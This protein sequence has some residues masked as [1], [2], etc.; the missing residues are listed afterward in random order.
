MH[1]EPEPDWMEIDS[2][3]NTSAKASESEIL[4]PTASVPSDNAEVTPVQKR[5]PREA[6]KVQDAFRYST[7]LIQGL[8]RGSTVLSNNTQTICNDRACFVCLFAAHIAWYQILS[9]SIR[10]LQI[11]GL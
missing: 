4:A 6:H 10:M 1:S 2:V 8:D 11:R 5:A 7:E 9:L 3:P